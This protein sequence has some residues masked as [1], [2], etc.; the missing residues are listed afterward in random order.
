M[1]IDIHSIREAIVSTIKKW[2]GPTQPV[3]QEQLT[4]KIPQLISTIEKLLLQTVSKPHRAQLLQVSE[5]LKD[6]S[7][8][9]ER[10]DEVICKLRELERDPDKH[11]EERADLLKEFDHLNEDLQKLVDLWKS[12]PFDVGAHGTGYPIY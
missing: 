2:M 10:R 12:D 1:L 5:Q 3:P 4:D 8:K 9:L 6:A 7:R 11:A